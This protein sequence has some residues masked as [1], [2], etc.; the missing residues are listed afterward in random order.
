MRSPKEN[1][2]LHAQHSAA[3]VPD[4]NEN[5]NQSHPDQFRAVPNVANLGGYA[6]GSTHHIAPVIGQFPTHLQ[7]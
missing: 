1:K 7:D 4:P 2:F 6:S 5:M 3:P